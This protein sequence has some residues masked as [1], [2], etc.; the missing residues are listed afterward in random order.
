MDGCNHNFS[1][2]VSTSIS[3]YSFCLFVCHNHNQ[4]I[5]SIMTYHQLVKSNTTLAVEQELPTLPE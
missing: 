3:R 5:A 4:V 2:N 1:L